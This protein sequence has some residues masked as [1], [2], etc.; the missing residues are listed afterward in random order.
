MKIKLKGIKVL[1]FVIQRKK[2]FIKEEGVP[3]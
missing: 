1:Y 3:S 2:D